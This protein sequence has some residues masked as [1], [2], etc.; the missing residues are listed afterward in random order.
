MANVRG[1]VF[2][3]EKGHYDTASRESPVDQ[4]NGTI[5]DPDAL[6]YGDTESDLR[7]MH[8]LGKKQEFK[9]STSIQV[10]AVQC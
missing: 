2:E 8:R 1:G 3:K 10:V 9:A 4:G 6:R 5:S 7:D